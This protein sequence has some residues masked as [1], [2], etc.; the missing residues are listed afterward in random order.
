[1]QYAAAG[2]NARAIVAKALEILPRLSDQ[3]RGLA[4]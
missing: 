3:R 2:L 1:L 4:V